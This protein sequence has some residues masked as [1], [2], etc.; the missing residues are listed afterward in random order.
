MDI[1]VTD[2]WTG[3]AQ[4]LEHVPHETELQVPEQQPPPAEAETVPLL[5]LLKEANSEKTR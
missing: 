3:Y 4:L 1:S 5:S 2:I